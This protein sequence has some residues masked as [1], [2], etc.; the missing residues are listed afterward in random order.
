MDKKIHRLP[1][2]GEYRKEAEEVVKMFW[3]VFG[4][5]IQRLNKIIE[6]K[7][8]KRSHLSVVK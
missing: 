4:S 6:E 7:K 8:S 1:L 2:M 5:D 3:E